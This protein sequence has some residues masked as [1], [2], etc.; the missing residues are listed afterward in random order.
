MKSKLNNTYED[1][2]K[3]MT[4]TYVTYVV[5]T[6]QAKSPVPS[7][8]GTNIVNVGN[9]DKPCG[10]KNGPLTPLRSYR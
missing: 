9:G 10:Y 3:K 6:E 1:F 4:V 8:N 5:A 2:K 7:Q